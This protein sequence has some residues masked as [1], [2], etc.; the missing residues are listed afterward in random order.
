MWHKDWPH[1]V[2]VFYVF[3]SSDFALYL[4][5]YLMDEVHTWDNGSVWHILINDGAGRGLFMP[6]WAL[7]PVADHHVSCFMTKPT[8]WPLRP[9]RTQISLDICPVWSGSSLSAT[10][11]I[12]SSATHWADVKP[13]MRLGGW[14][15]KLIWVFAGCTCHFVGFVMS[16]LNCVLFIIGPGQTLQLCETHNHTRRSSGPDPPSSTDTGQWYDYIIM[17]QPQQVT[18][19]LRH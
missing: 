6:L 18:C 12:G 9:L 13:L 1:E 3:W 8:K 16:W 17:C 2:Y 14:M 5:N 10:R 15:A 11:N 19:D 4:E 7:A